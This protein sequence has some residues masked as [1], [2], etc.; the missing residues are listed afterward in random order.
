MPVAAADLHGLRAYAWSFTGYTIA[1]LIANVLSGRA[2]DARGPR[3]PLLVGEAFFVVGLFVSGLAP[4]MV[5]FVGGR[6]LQ[7]FGSGAII[8]AI[9]VVIGR[10]FDDQ[11]R[12][13]VFSVMA[14]AW[15]IPSLVGPLV[16]GTLAQHASW[17]WAFLGVPI[18][19]AP[20]L[21]AIYPTLSRRELREPVGTSEFRSPIPAAVLTAVGVGLIQQGGTT[22]GWLGLVLAVVG[23][24]LLVPNIGRLLPAGALRLKRG[25]PSVILMR[26]VLSATFF[27][28]ETFIPLMLVSQRHVSP[29]LAGFVL[30]SSA[31]G[32]AS[33]SWYQ[34]RPTMRHSRYTLIRVGSAVMVCSIAGIAVA[35]VAPLPALVVFASWTVGGFGMGLSLA[36]I[37]VLTLEL[38]PPEEQGRNSSALQV[39]D[40]ALSSVAIAIGGAIVTAGL[41]AGTHHPIVFVWVDAFAALIGVGGMILATRLRPQ[42]AAH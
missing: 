42:P 41:V 3:F 20:A 30:A 1:A 39:S 32:W 12:P 38:S 29:T 11:I 19:V 6:L 25:L 36:S 17:R 18:L 37:N 28:T 22:L 26:G 10:V 5:S 2:S 7:G 34:G 16:A 8:V 31:I 24:A 27:A 13:R 21:W 15:I 14:S 9:Y 33:G 23:V 40:A 35:A 4:N